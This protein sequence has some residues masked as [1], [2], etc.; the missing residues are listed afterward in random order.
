MSATFFKTFDETQAWLD[1]MGIERYT[2]HSNLTV[3]CASTVNLSSQKLDHIPVQFGVVRGI[4]NVNFNALTSL[5][6]APSKCGGFHC[7]GNP[8]LIDIHAAPIECRYIYCDYDLVAKNQAARQL[9]EL[10]S[11]SSVTGSGTK[12]H[13]AL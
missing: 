1:K 13:R 12:Q 9:A 11:E 8:G 2:I 4:F 5:N 10:E 6:G 7:L 3:D